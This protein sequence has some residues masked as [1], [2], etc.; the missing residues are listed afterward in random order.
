VASD[1]F[2]NTCRIQNGPKKINAIEP[3]AVPA[4]FS[5]HVETFHRIEHADTLMSGAARLILQIICW[6]TAQRLAVSSFTLSMEHERGRD[7][8]APTPLDIVLAEPAWKEPHLLRLLKERL[9]KLELMA[10]VI[11]LR[12]TAGQLVAILPPTD[13][14]FPEPGGSPEDFTRATGTPGGQTGCRQRVDADPFA[15]PQA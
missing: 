1:Q 7:A 5:V 4:A 15:R 10:P 14:L 13:Q 8:I 2:L 12:L 11:G 3:I 9:S 6:L